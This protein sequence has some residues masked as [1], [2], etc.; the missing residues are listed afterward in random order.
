MAYRPI[1]RA[2]SETFQDNRWNTDGQW[3]GYNVGPRRS[4]PAE[5]PYR[6][7]RKGR[8][9]EGK[10][11]IRGFKATMYL[12]RP[13][14]GKRAGTKGRLLDALSGEGP[15]VFAVKCGDKRTLMRDRPQRWMWSGWAI[16]EV[17]STEAMLF[18]KDFRRKDLRRPRDFSSSIEK[19]R[20]SKSR[21]NFQTRR[22]QSEREPLTRPPE[23]I[24]TDAR[25]ADGARH[26]DRFPLSYRDANREWWTR[27]PP[28]SGNYAGGRPRNFPGDIWS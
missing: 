14:D 9:Y 7:Q 25:W 20:A 13:S 27:V 1:D 19:T 28:D 24:W 22:Y 17:Q 2:W 8:W 4:A 11:E 3:S 6:T 26:Q 5:P 18:D 23:D 12:V 21:Y 15:D 10:R 16:S